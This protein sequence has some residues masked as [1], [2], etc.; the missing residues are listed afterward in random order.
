MDALWQRLMEL[1]WAQLSLDWGGRIALALAV[2]FGGLWLSRLLVRVLSR[3]LDRAGTDPMLRDFLRQVT[4][5][6]MMVV[7]VIAALDQLGV[8]TTSLLA[9]LGAAGLAVGL[10]LRDSLSNLAAG[11]M[12]ILLKPFRAG[13]VVRIGVETGKVESLRLMHTVLVT[14]DNCELVLPN[15]RVANEAILNY[16]ARGTRRL[17]LLLGLGYGSDL[18]AAMSVIRTV[19]AGDARVLPE[20][21]VEIAIVTLTDTRVEIAVRPWTRTT[22]YWPLRSDLLLLLKQQLMAAGFEL[23]LPAR[24]VLIRAERGGE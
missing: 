7:V 3:V 23:P 5:G 9:A 1:P 21:A 16:T 4:R 8:P 14:A 19:L 11:V 13:D 15:N 18:A 24:E 6:A 20:P 2:L 22:D 12:L 10:A 17:E